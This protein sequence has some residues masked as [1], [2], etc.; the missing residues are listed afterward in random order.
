MNQLLIQNVSIFNEENTLSKKDLLIEENSIK[1]IQPGNSLSQNKNNFIDILEGTEF[2]A[3]PGLMNCHTHI[4]MVLF[5]GFAEDLNLNDWLQKKIFPL[6]SKLSEELVFY[7]ALMGI[8]ELIHNGCT[9]FADMYFYMESVAKAVELSGIRANLSIGLVDQDAKNGIHK[10]ESFFNQYHQSANDRI[11]VFVGPHAPYTCNLT[12]LKQV[13]MLAKSLQTG[14]HIHLN[15][16]EKEVID[17]VSLNQKRPII[18][19]K[20]IDF[21]GTSTICAHCVHVNEEEIDILKDVNAL[22][23][24]NPSSNMKLGSGIA[25]I[26]D[27]IKKQIDVS[28]GTDGAASN[29]QLNMFSEMHLASLLGKVSSKTGSALPVNTVYKMGTDVPGRYLY[30]NKV[31]SIKEGCLADIILIKLSSPSL[32]PNDNISKSLIHSIHGNEV[33][34]VIINGKIVMK[35]HLILTMNEKEIQKTANELIRK[36]YLC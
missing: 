8:A 4:P 32:F 3:M 10:T 17:F 20:D 1:C 13:S 16:T 33:D 36:T 2:L 22:I 11:R 35:N 23:V 18:A 24:H 29:N 27:M 9:F 19:L 14:I 15:E 5:R 30:N 25:P 7:G 34:T 31:G 6:E 12:F 26:N 21:F 28:L